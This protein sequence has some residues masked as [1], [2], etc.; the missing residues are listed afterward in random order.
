MARTLNR[1]TDRKVKTARAGMHSDGGGLWLQVS[2][3]GDSLNRSW[4]FRFATG[5]TVVSKKGKKRSRERQMGLGSVNDVTLAEAR[6]RA[7]ECRKM[8]QRAVDPIE[9]KR[10]ERGAQ[11]V[12]AARALTFDQCSEAYIAAHRSGW[13]NAKHAAQWPSSLKA[14]A[15]PVFWQAAGRSGRPSPCH[16]GAGT[17]LEGHTGDGE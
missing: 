8:R 2:G 6:E 11:A 7:A 10:V 9:A 17:D 5:E 16:E 13:R 1:L 4:I 15:S 3:T 12:A 14:H